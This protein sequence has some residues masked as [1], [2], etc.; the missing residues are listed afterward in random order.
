MKKRLWEEVV[1]KAVYTQ[2]LNIKQDGESPPPPN[3]LIETSVCDHNN[4]HT[5]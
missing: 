1:A 2:G 5:W 3:P 4:V